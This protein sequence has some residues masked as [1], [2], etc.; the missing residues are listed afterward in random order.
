[1]RDVLHGMQEVAGS[2]PVGST[3]RIVKLAQSHVYSV[4]GFCILHVRHIWLADLTD[5][6]IH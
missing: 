5:A 1:M 6:Y 3:I 2:I 4:R